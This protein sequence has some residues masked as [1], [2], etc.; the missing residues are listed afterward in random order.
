[1]LTVEQQELL[2]QDAPDVRLWIGSP[3]ALGARLEVVPFQ[4]DALRYVM[5][6]VHPSDFLG[7]LSDAE[8]Q[9]YAQKWSQGY[10]PQHSA[11]LVK[12]LRAEAV[13][14]MFDPGA[15]PLPKPHS[16]FELGTVLRDAWSQHRKSVP[17]TE[18]YFYIATD[19]RLAKFYGRIFVKS[20]TSEHLSSFEPILEPLGEFYGYRKKT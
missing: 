18:Q 1:M 12:F 5:V 19:S 9:D 17:G 13:A 15:W 16:I 4:Y 10:V 14:D 20:S 6:F 8:L 7:D 11:R 3:Q 2:F